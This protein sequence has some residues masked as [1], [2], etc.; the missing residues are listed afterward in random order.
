M[1]T[2]PENGSTSSFPPD[3][4]D[5][6]FAQLSA[7]WYDLHKPYEIHTDKKPVKFVPCLDCRRAMVVTTFYVPAWAHCRACSGKIDKGG[8]ATI[9]VPQAGKTDPEKAI[10]LADCLVNEEFAEAACPKCGDDMELKSIHHNPNYGPRIQVGV[11]KKSGDPVYEMQLGEVVMHQ[12]NHCRTTL[13]FSTTAQM[14]YRRQNEIVRTAGARPATEYILG[15][16]EE[17]AA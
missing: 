8:V 13:S 6:Y 5:S 12:C 7:E 9:A 11:D 15:P 4:V 17:E 16:R 2:N 14:V 10:N 1:I 3:Q